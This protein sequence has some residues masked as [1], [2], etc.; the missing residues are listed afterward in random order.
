MQFNFRDKF[1]SR[2]IL[3]TFGE[4]LVKGSKFL[5]IPFYT[6]V[7]TV[8]EFGILQQILL[9]AAPLGFLIDFST[10]ESLLKLYFDYK[11]KNQ[12]K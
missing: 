10:K 5:L 4:F 6:R 1:F 12:E 3:Y 2:T 9:V 8:E 7:F 11:K